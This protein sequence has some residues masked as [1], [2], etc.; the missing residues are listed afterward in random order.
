M[1]SRLEF[2]E[3]DLR[4]NDELSNTVARLIVAELIDH[5]P[6]TLGPGAE[7]YLE[8]HPL[9]ERRHFILMCND[10]LAGTISIRSDRTRTGVLSV[11]GLVVDETHRGNGYG[12]VMLGLVAR[13]ANIDGIEALSLGT[14]I[15]SYFAK[16]CFEG[17]RR[18]MVA[19]IDRVVALTN[20]TQEEAS[21]LA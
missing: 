18:D 19:P 1:A 8:R 3:I 7:A 14:W 17:G 6:G 15:P 16:Y 21:I 12:R 13:Q 2:R 10:G 20:V 5:N 9:T 11:D 4:K